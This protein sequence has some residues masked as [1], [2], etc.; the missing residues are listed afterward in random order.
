MTERI[1]YDDD[2]LNTIEKINNLLSEHKLFVAITSEDDA[3][4]LDIEI[5]TS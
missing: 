1:Y 2:S 3:E 5:T 4:H